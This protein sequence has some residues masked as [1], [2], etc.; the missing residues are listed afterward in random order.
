MGHLHLLDLFDTHELDEIFGA[1]KAPNSGIGSCSLKKLPPRE[2][3][4]HLDVY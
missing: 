2:V 1:I 3:L 4:L